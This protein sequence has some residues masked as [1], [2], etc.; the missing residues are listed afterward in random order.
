MKLLYFSGFCLQNEKNIFDEYLTINEFTLNGFSYGCIKL[1][2]YALICDSRIDKIQLFSPAYFNDKDEKFKRMQLMFFKKDATL[3]ADNFLKNCG[4]NK[5][6]KNKY[7]S[8]GTFGELKELLYYEWKTDKLQT[9][10]DRG[11]EIETYIG[12]DD[13]IIDPQETLEFFRRFGDTYWIKKAG[14]ILC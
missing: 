9:L 7:F 12:E 3:Y 11:I 13:K 10:K 6:N 4:F 1:I 14:H 8:F 5:E 2:E